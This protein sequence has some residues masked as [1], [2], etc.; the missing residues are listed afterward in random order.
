MSTRPALRILRI[1]SSAR[2]DGSVSRR[3]GDEIEQ[4]LLRRHPEATRVYRDLADG[5]PWIDAGWVEASLAGDSR[6]PAQ[7]ERLALSDQLVDEL[8]QADVV[9]LTA[10][11][12]NFSVP[13]VLKAWIDQVCRAGRTFRYTPN[14]PDGLLADRPVYL[15]MASGGVPFGSPVDFASGYLAQVFR[16]VGISD[17]RF[18]GAEGVAADADGAEARALQ[19]LS[20]WLP[21]D[22]AEA[23]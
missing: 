5:L 22:D 8:V 14:G 18:V 19:Q 3:I 1:D 16:F 17:V 12:Y 11:I 10:P 20:Q 9:V 21:E 6:D 2:A 4:R 7:A 13:S 23:A 15:A